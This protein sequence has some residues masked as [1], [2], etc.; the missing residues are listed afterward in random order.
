[1][2]DDFTLV[3]KANKGDK[4]AFSLLLER[5]YD[6][7]YRIG[8]RM[9]QNQADA[10]D[11]AQDI[12][13]SL[14]GK[15]QSFQGQSKLTTWLY[16]VT[17]NSARDFLRRR[18]TIAKIHGEFADLQDLQKGA[19]AQQKDDVEWAYN[20]INSMPEDLRETALLIVAEGLSHA[21][22]GEVLNVKEATVSWRMMKVR[23]HLK[24]LVGEE[25]KAETS[26]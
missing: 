13:V 25:A 23:E 19:E 9:L 4:R 21:E 6:L 17:M 15:L 10:E 12:C 8:F 20:A 24:A 26:R 5:H 3:Q 11:L 16:Q 7:I 2:I 22:A 1:M 18:V 14:A